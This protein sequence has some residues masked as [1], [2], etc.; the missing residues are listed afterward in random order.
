[1]GRCIL[2]IGKDFSDN[3]IWNE[4]AKN[5]NIKLITL[6]WCEIV[7]FTSIRTCHRKQKILIGDALRLQCDKL[8]GVLH[9]DVARLDMS[10]MQTEG[11]NYVKL[12][13]QA[14]WLS[15]QPH[16]KQIVNKAHHKH[17]CAEFW[18]APSVYQQ[19]KKCGLEVAEW[20][21]DSRANTGKKHNEESK[22]IKVFSVIEQPGEKV[23]CLVVGHKVFSIGDLAVSEVISMPRDIPSKL[24]AFRL[25]L[26]LTV[27]EV[28]F[29]QYQDSWVLHGIRPKPNWDNWRKI[30]HYN[31]V[32]QLLKSKQEKQRRCLI[33]KKRRPI[34][35]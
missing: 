25:R 1:M 4:T 26:S 16:L 17:Y 2:A 19:A 8:L 7:R 23:L 10:S 6:S 22:R 27:M 31:A 28:Y 29:K 33:S 30:E 11:V 24:Q 9:F 18:S 12:A 5:H 34:I 20:V 15:M 3:P 32:W 14:W 35:V 13:W 21:C